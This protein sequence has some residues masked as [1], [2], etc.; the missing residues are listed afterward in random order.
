MNARH[1]ILGLA[2][3]AVLGRTPLGTQQPPPGQGAPPTG[4]GMI[5]GKVLDADSGQGIPGAMVTLSLARAGGASV[6]LVQARF[7]SVLTDSQG[8]F[9]FTM[10]PAGTFMG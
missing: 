10:L 6:G 8:R 4:T 5:A 1:L 3:C 9:V 2:T 7:P